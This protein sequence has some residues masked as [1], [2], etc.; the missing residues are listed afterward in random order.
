M[1]ELGALGLAFIEVSGGT[2]EAPAMVVNKQSTR[3][4]EAYFLAFAE[5]VRDRVPGPLVVTGGFRSG[6]AMTAALESGAVDL[7]GMARVL[8]AYPDFPN[9][10]LADPTAGVDL[11]KPA[12]GSAGST[13]PGCRRW[14]G[15]P[16]SSTAWARDRNPVRRRGRSPRCA[17]TS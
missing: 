6:P 10:V 5:A 13:S 1:A 16:G 2:Y 15:S 12:P 3:D 7:V 9:T 8:A 4:R 11:P 14:S 17:G